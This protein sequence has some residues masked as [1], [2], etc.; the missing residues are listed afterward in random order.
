MAWGLAGHRLLPCMSEPLE[1][2]EQKSSMFSIPAVTN[3]KF[4]GLKQH[5]LTVSQFLRSGVRHRSHGDKSEVLTGLCAFWRLQGRML[6]CVFKLPE[7]L[8]IFKASSVHF[9]GHFS[10]V[11]SAS[12]HSHF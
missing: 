4:S 3:R 10:V 6:P 12:D 2:S 8:S 1:G 9:C 5:K 11:T 7:T